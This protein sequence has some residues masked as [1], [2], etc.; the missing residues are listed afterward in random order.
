MLYAPQNAK[1]TAPIIQIQIG[2]VRITKWLISATG[3]AMNNI[4][5]SAFQNLGSGMS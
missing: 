2:H 4:A 3:I 1:S 5:M